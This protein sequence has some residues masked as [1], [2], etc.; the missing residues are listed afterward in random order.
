MTESFNAKTIGDIIVKSLGLLPNDTIEI[1]RDRLDPRRIL[2][3]RVT[4]TDKQDHS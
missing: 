1:R 4:D 2:V 3:L